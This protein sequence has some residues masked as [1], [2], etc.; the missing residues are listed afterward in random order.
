[1]Q[2]VEALC[3][4]IAVI[5]EGRIVAFGTPDELRAETGQQSLEDVFMKTAHQT[6]PEEKVS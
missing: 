2:E 6:Q 4:R 5:A 1:M 3:D